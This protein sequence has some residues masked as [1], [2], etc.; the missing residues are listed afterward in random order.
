L[1]PV[2][3][4]AHPH[5]GIFVILHLTPA[6]GKSYNDAFAIDR[7]LSNGARGLMLLL[8]KLDPRAPRDIKSLAAILQDGQ[9][10][11]ARQMAELRQR[12]YLTVRRLKDRITGTIAT[13]VDLYDSPQASPSLSTPRSGSPGQQTLGSTSGRDNPPPLPPEIPAPAPSVPEGGR[14]DLPQPEET[15]ADAANVAL[16]AR[17]GRENPRL[18]LGRR[19]MAPLMPLL[20][21][22]RARGASEAHIRLALSEGLPE[23][24]YS[25][26]GLLMTRLR[27]KMPEMVVQHPV[28][29]SVS[30]LPE[31][32]DCGRPVNGRG[33][34]GE[35]SPRSSRVTEI[36]ETCGRGAAMAR[37]AAIEALEK[38]RILAHTA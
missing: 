13:Y 15:L 23:R 4:F 35:C 31:C 9:G 21:E 36:T 24:V 28:Q 8:I 20:T 1:Q 26:S 2:P 5:Q 3:F 19:E 16:L 6:G 30:A 27:N 38:G 25:P 32:T 18:A 14:E 29:P 37:Q 12:G 7:T 11:V 17:L 10:A 22:W 34:C 33:E